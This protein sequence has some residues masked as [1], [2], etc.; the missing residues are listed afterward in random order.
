MTGWIGHERRRRQRSL[1][2]WTDRQTGMCH[3]HLELDPETDARVAAALDAAVTAE[4]AADEASGQ[5]R[6]FDQLKADAA[7]ALITGASAVD[8]RVPEISVL[9]DL[10]TLRDQLRDD[11]VCETAD[12]NPVPPE[13]VRRLA[14]E[15]TIIP[16]VL[17]G[18]GVPLDM[19]RARRVATREQR[20]VLRAMYQTCA[21]PGCGVRF[22]EC[23]IH[24]A[25]HWTRDGVTGPAL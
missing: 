14:C 7:V 12:G 6:T 24:H 23:D 11:G 5:A 20:R 17:D 19:G 8:P 16:I 4:R 25:V 18:D 3:T 22:G 2:R 21:Y 10:D 13:T 9:I 15:A 1:C